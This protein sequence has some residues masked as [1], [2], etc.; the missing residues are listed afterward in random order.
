MSRSLPIADILHFDNL[1]ESSDNGFGFG[2]GQRVE[3]VQRRS[4]IVRLR[5]KSIP[6]Y[7][8]PKVTFH[9]HGHRARAKEGERH[10][11]ER[12]KRTE[13]AIKLPEERF[14]R[15]RQSKRKDE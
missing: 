5:R 11:S 8:G 2:C 13:V 12:E 7:S 10:E 14:E 15:A 3:S 4:G 6:K 1:L 9:R